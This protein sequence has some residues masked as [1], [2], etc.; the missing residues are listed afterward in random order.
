MEPSQR[1]TQ[2]SAPCAPAT[3]EERAAAYEPDTA[4]TILEH[5]VALSVSLGLGLATWTCLAAGPSGSGLF[6]VAVAVA[7]MV[8]GALLPSSPFQIGAGLIVG[9]L[10]VSPWTTSR[11]D[12]DG[13]WVLIIPMLGGLGLFLIA[14]AAIAAMIGREFVRTG[15]PTGC[16]LLRARAAVRPWWLLVVLVSVA[17]T[18]G[19]GL[20]LPSRIP[21][22][23]PRLE[24]TIAGFDTPTSFTPEGTERRGDALCERSCLP[25][26]VATFSTW[27]TPADACTALDTALRGWATDVGFETHNQAALDPE[28]CG[29]HGVIDDGDHTFLVRASLRPS[30]TS[31]PSELRADVEI[32]A[33]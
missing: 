28:M 15:T 12:G 4:F 14:G 1:R 31:T 26:V 29:G 9:P 32:E 19:A 23:W 6:F 13:L 17:A 11:G 21:D 8:L 18:V 3:P 30:P 20:A 7:A 2:S 27:A 5:L 24:A 33:S 10:L 25:S 16:C 22:P